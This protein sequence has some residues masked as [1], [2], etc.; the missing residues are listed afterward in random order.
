MKTV[1][2]HCEHNIHINFTRS[3]FGLLELVRHLHNHNTITT[4]CSTVYFV[5]VL[6]D[7]VLRF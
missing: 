2:V 3:T 5:Y 1:H 6:P 7:C 4:C